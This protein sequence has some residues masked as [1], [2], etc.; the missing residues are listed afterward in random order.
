MFTST[1]AGCRMSPVLEAIGKSCDLELS[2]EPITLAPRD[3]LA[4]VEAA[5]RYYLVSIARVGGDTQQ[6]VKIVFAKQATDEN[7]PL[8]G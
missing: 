7:P 1:P 8:S 4:D 5:E 3:V 2:A 6:S